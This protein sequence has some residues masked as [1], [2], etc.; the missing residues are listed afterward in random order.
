MQVKNW[1]FTASGKNRIETVRIQ[2]SLHKPVRGEHA[3]LANAE[4]SN[5]SLQQGTKL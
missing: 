3:R 5:Q 2:D 4:I 1:W